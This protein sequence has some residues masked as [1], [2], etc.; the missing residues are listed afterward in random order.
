[1]LAVIVIV[2]VLISL[3]SGL[4]LVVLFSDKSRLDR[5]L[6]IFAYIMSWVYG[7]STMITLY[8]C[9]HYLYYRGEEIMFL[10]TK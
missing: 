4:T 2:I 6:R 3:L 5:P 1:M 7:V 9:C 8:L 10:L